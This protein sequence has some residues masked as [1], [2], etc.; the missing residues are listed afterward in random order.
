LKAWNDIESLSV[1]CGISTR[2]GYR[3]LRSG[4]LKKKRLEDGRRVFVLDEDAEINRSLTD[5][6]DMSRMSG[7]DML[8]VSV[9]RDKGDKNLTHRL[10]KVKRPSTELIQ[11]RERTE[12]LELKVNQAKSQ[13][14]LEK[15]LEGK[16]REEADRRKAMQRKA[17]LQRWVSYGLRYFNPFYIP[18]D[19]KVRTRKAIESSL[20]D[21]DFSEDPDAV[22]LMIE[23]VVNELREDYCQKVLYPE[24]KAELIHDSVRSLRFPYWVTSEIQGRIRSEVRKQMEITFEGWEDPEEYFSMAKDLVNKMIASLH[25]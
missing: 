25:Y 6:A 17:W 19:W 22:R 10:Y 13:R 23:Q 8:K 16:R 24:A 5:D 9:D 3:W 14:E 2:T 11:E 7:D 21:L 1:D 12:A 20:Q 4:K 18:L 15:L